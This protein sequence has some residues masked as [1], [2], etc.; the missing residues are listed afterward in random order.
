MS[1]TLDERHTPPKRRSN[2]SEIHDYFAFRLQKAVDK[3]EALE[4]RLAAV[5]EL[6]TSHEDRFEISLRDNHQNVYVPIE[7]C[8]QNEYGNEIIKKT[9]VKPEAKLCPKI[10]TKSKQ[11]GTSTRQD[12]QNNTE[13]KL[14]VKTVVSEQ[15]Y[16]YHYENQ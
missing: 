9:D 3:Y 1:R 7:S 8:M 13:D 15:E 12:S 6:V 11:T 16:V 14:D 5:E 2:F 4:E 10:E